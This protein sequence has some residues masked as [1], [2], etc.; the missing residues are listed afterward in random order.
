MDGSAR[1]RLHGHAEQFKGACGALSAPFAHKHMYPSTTRMGGQP[2]VTLMASPGLSK[3]RGLGLP[4]SGH[5]SFLQSFSALSG[6]RQGGGGGIAT[7]HGPTLGHGAFSLLGT[8]GRVREWEGCCYC[9]Y[10]PEC[11][12]FDVLSGVC[13]SKPTL[14]RALHL[15]R[16]ILRAV[17]NQ[18]QALRSPFLHVSGLGLSY[19]G[20]HARTS[21]ALSKFGDPVTP[22]FS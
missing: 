10:G 7:S 22:L 16:H 21:T 3:L 14:H 20:L 13:T 4:L 15:S 19:H 2:M 11:I 6:L 1:R 9:P 12:V 8:A 5:P 17:P 18:Q